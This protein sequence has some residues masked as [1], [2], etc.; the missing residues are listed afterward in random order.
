M[1]CKMHTI[2]SWCTMRISTNYVSSVMLRPKNKKKLE[3]RNVSLRS[4]FFLCLL[5]W[6]SVNINV[7]NPVGNTNPRIGQTLASGYTRGGITCLGGVSIPYRPVT[8]AVSSGERCEPWS[9]SEYQELVW[10]TSDSI[11]PKGR[12]YW[13]TRSL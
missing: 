4:Y 6:N 7:M 1:Q 2:P 3:I 5:L 8:S 10:N 12:L 13:Q 9:R 11:W